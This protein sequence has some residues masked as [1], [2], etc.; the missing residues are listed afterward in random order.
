MAAFLKYLY[1]PVNWHILS[2]ALVVHLQR[3][4]CCQETKYSALKLVESA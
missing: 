2:T 4:L 3:A 1:G